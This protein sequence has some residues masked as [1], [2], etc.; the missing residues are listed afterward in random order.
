MSSWLPRLA[1]LVLLSLP[2]TAQSTVQLMLT[3]SVQ[4]PKGGSIDVEIAV[5][6]PDG[7]EGTVVSLHMVLL[8][9]TTALDVATLLDARLTEAKI[10]HVAPAAASERDRATLFVDGV[11]RVLLRVGDGLHARVGLPEGAPTSVQLLPPL[12]LPGKANLFVRGTTQDAR[13]RQRGSIEFSVELAADS[14]PTQAVELLS[15]A[16]ARANWLS[17]RPNHD[18]WKPSPNFEGLQ[19][20]GTS[21]DLDTTASDWGIELR[22]P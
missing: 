10:R 9:S 11:S 6:G 2:A 7:R 22:L 8:S 14:T 16:C 21:F 13:L 18:T 4:N 19:L 15:N 17:E 1:A 3:G 5:R 12:S 20:V